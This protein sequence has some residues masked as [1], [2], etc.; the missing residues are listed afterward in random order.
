MPDE[1]RRAVQH[2][3]LFA[4]VL[5][6]SGANLDLLRLLPWKAT[7]HDGFPSARVLLLSQASIVLEDVPQ[8]ALQIAYLA[9]PAE[10]ATAAVPALSLA[11]SLI[12][13]LWRSLKKLLVS[14]SATSTT[15]EGAASDAERPSRHALLRATLRAALT[16]APPRSAYNDAELTLASSTQRSSA[17]TTGHELV[18]LER[19]PAF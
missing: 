8:A 11:L 4:A 18:P 3:K 1:P 9:G 13:L 17:G 12:S 2:A 6:A 5:V 10:A 19:E 14:V 15:R 16:G 7:K